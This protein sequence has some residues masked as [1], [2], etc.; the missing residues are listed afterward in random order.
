MF[1]LK[2]KKYGNIRIPELRI[3][4][5]LYEAESGKG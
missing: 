2:N 5:P 4:L 1:S 3:N